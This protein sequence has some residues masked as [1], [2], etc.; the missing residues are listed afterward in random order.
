MKIVL[1]VLL[2]LLLGLIIALLLV[3]ILFKG[4]LIDFIK[5]KL[6]E[7][8]H[9]TV[10]FDDVSL[11]LIKAFPSVSVDLDNLRVQGVDEFK[12]ATLFSADK[13]HLTTDLKSIIKPAEGIN[14]KK[15]SV[16]RPVANILITKS[17]KQNYDI[18]KDKTDS[19]NESAGN[20]FGQ[21]E[22]YVIKD[23]KFNY[24][25]LQNNTEVSLDNLNHEGKGNF[26][27]VAFD[28]D[29]KT[30]IA[31]MNF[32]S[33]GISY[34]NDAKLAAD[35]VLGVDMD[36]QLYAFKENEISLNDLD[37]SFVG[38][39]QSIGSGFGLN[40]DLK[41]PNNKVSSILSLIPSSYKGNFEDIQSSG[42]SFL[43]GS[44]KGTFDSV[45]E[46]F[47]KTNLVATIENG[48]MK[49][50]SLPLPV[51]DINM[52]MKVSADKQ[53]WSDMAVNVDNFSFLVKDDRMSGKMNILNAMTNPSIDGIIDGTLNLKNISQA[54]PV[55]N[56]RLNKG[57]IKAKIVAKAT[58]SD[59]ENKNYNKMSFDGDIDVSDM[60]LS[61]EQWPVTLTKSKSKLKPSAISTSISELKVGKSDFNGT[62]NIVEPL[63]YLSAENS[64]SL[65]FDIQSQLLDADE[66]QALSTVETSSTESSAT[67]TADSTQAINFDEYKEYKISGNYSA[68]K[69]KYEDYDVEK[70][71]TKFKFQNDKLDL[72]STDFLLNESPTSL[73]GSAENLIDYVMADETLTGKFFFNSDKI[74]ADDFMGSETTT[75][76]EPQPFIVDEKWDMEI[77]PEIKSLSYDTYLLESLEGKITIADGIAQIE[78]GSAYSMG[79]KMIVDGLYNSTDASNPLFDLRYKLDKI[80]F[81]EIFNASE[82]FKILAP[83]AKYIDGALNSTLIMSGPLN[84]DMT[85][86]LN[87]LTASGFLETLKGVING[88]GPLEKIGNALGIEK[89]K[90]MTIDGSKNWF[91]V[92]DGVVILKPH[93]HQVDDMVFNVAGNHSLDQTIDYTIKAQI[94]R[95]KLKKDKLG[96]N[97]E[98]GMD[99][100][101]KEAGSRGVNIDLG[102]MIYLDIFL[103]GNIKS[104]KIKV[105]PV[106]SG[107]KTLNE[108]VKNEVTKQVNVLKDTLQTELGKKTEQVKD[109]VSKV[110]N[111]ETDRIKQKAKDKVNE[112]AEKQK[113]KIRDAL[114]GKADS[115]VTKI[116]TDTLQDKVMDKTRE[117]LGDQGAGK[118]DSLKDKLKEWNP[119]KKKGGN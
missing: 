17:G 26:K 90:K 52:K 109:T 53:D 69:V 65:N 110:I 8:V 75:T 106:G 70:L 86:N 64:P 35:V 10:D 55:D 102:E 9:A 46:I 119:F 25:D 59:I 83:I 117:V 88:F 15:I 91:D 40:L 45:K 66:L 87:K 12:D 96:K 44:I 63:A 6:N 71:N 33:G 34:I 62:V 98:Y 79:G 18:V 21:L 2:W 30:S 7:E 49:Y 37:V 99:F 82:S 76:A 68:V 22:S 57:I 73:R 32:S 115:A 54:F 31:G 107:G 111:K 47:P 29:T 101:E 5:D 19:N 24:Q 23:A 43:E 92:K 60:D 13:I 100:L 36:K 93:D 114:K 80:A 84:Q 85:P 20:F 14:I 27:G 4:E 11:S 77:Y 94:P 89:L 3:P 67:I 50:P 116:L 58:A 42:N 108:V 112:E 113:S 105:L 56:M 104:P 78:D 28:L 81:K 74:N 16:E 95:D 1:R 51:N 97:L 103:T 39:V 38:T 41:A 48:S 61:Y 72:H 118:V